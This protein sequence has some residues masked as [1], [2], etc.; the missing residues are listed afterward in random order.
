VSKTRANRHA[1]SR[2]E[3]IAGL[4]D[5]TPAVSATAEELV[6]EARELRRGFRGFVE[7]DDLE[8]FRS[9]GRA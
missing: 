4:R 5:V 9:E 8:R 3:V 7:D 2:R 1:R 6:A